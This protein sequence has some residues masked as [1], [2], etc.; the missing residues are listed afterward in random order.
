MNDQL[1]TL[2]TIAPEKSRP[3][4][5]PAPRSG[6]GFS[7]LK[8][9]PAP[10]PDDDEEEDSWLGR[11]AVALIGGALAVAIGVWFYLH[12]PS[13]KLEPVRKAPETVVRI[14]LPPP[15]P[16]PPP[17]KIQPPPPKEDKR[18]EQTPLAKPEPKREAE[19]PKPA[20]K[21]PEGLGTN[22]KGAGPGL[23]GLGSSGNGVLGGTGTNGAG[24]GRSMARWYV[25]QIVSKVTE[26]MR[27]NRRTRTASLRVDARIWLDSSGRITRAELVN[28][29][30]DAS[31]DT[32][33]KNEVLVGTQ[34]AEP[35][36]AGMRMPIPL[37]LTARRPN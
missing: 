16:P 34:L 28:S 30:G 5:E 15:P 32:A 21:P 9:A 2:E 8:P 23:A 20:E 14:Q 6:R 12:P 13:G 25:G 36:P 33:L 31:L 24:T 10:P 3:P 29:T 11:H 19:K 27:G 37:R 26:V 1:E 17:P 35:P 7:P 18:L 22:V 4:A